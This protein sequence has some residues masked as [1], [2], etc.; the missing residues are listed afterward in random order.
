MNHKDSGVSFPWVSAGTYKKAAAIGI[1]YGTQLQMKRKS[2]CNS[3]ICCHFVCVR[4]ISF[5]PTS[6]P[7]LFYTSPGLASCLADR[8][9]PLLHHSRANSR[10]EFWEQ[11]LA[12]AWEYKQKKSLGILSWVKLISKKLIWICLHL[13]YRYACHHLYFLNIGIEFLANEG[14]VNVLWHFMN[15]SLL[16]SKRPVFKSGNCQMLKATIAETLNFC[17]NSGLID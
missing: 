2:L 12:G 16:F 3:A 7:S 8:V 15:M 14:S 10:S 9:F 11:T 13:P 17:H 4:N 6:F 1:W 5:C